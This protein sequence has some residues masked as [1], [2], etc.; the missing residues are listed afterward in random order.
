MRKAQILNL[1]DV[2]Q[3]YLNYNPVTGD[4]IWVK[5]RGGESK[6]NTPVACFD[7]GG[8]R[9]VHINGKT[10]K[11][12]IICWLLYYKDLPTQM[13]D[14]VNRNPGDNRINNLR[15]VSRSENGRNTDRIDEG[16]LVGA[17]PYYNKWVSRLTYNKQRYYVGLFNTQQEAHEAY[18]CKLKNLSR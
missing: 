5:K 6:L 11:A 12:H 16:H 7:I 1:L 9:R 2:C 4:L 10:Y 15:G 13:I 3:K 14:H 18:L 17:Y 8:Y